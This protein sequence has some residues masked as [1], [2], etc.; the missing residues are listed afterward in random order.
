[1]HAL[2]KLAQ[3][4]DTA[5]SITAPFHQKNSIRMRRSSWL[6]LTCVLSSSVIPYRDS[7]MIA[8]CQSMTNTTGRICVVMRCTME[9]S[10]QKL[11]K[12]LPLF[13]FR[14]SR[15][16]RFASCTAGHHC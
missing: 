12:P 3:Q 7:G 10:W 2:E 14:V 11:R 5:A 16:T 4:A 6:R 15:H 9:L 13:A 1:M 8:F